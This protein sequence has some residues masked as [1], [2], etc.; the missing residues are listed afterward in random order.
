MR[1]DDV[2][3]L[4]RGPAERHSAADIHARLWTAVGHPELAAA[5]EVVAG[6]AVV[7]D[8]EAADRLRRANRAE[9]VRI[10]ARDLSADDPLGLVDDVAGELS[11]LADGVLACALAIARSQVPGADAIRFAVIG[12]GKCGARELNYLSDV[13]V[14]Y[15]AEPRADDGPTAVE[16]AVAVGNRL[17]AALARLC[18]AHTAA[19]SIWQLDA[20]LRPEGNAGPLARTLDA[21]SAYYHR[22]ASDWEF[23]ALLKARPVAGDRALG[24]AFCEAVAPLVWQVGSHEGFIG[25][26]RAMRQRV[27]DHIPSDQRDREVK[28]G[29]GGLRDIEFS[30][31]ILQLVHG[32]A[33][34]RLRLADTLGG[35]RALT[36]H[37]Y[38]GRPEGELLASAYRFERCLEHRAQ[39]WHLHRTHLLPTEPA[40]QRR[41]ARSLRGGPDDD[42]W[43]R[44]R[45]TS[46]QVRQ[47]QQRVFYS[48]LLEAVSRVPSDALALSSEAAADRLR[49]LG[50]LDQQAAL[51]HIAAL[52]D[53]V[54]R[55]AEIQR[56][57][58]PAMLGW[59]AEGPNPDA[60]LLAFRQISD[61]LGT[62]AWYL[63]AL[64]DEG[65]T[66]ERLAR[67]PA[68]SRYVVDLLRRDPSSIQ[69][70]SEDA[71]LV[72]RSRA[73]LT[74][75]MTQ[76]GARHAN[77]AEAIEAIRALRRRELCRIALGDLV[78]TLDL[79]AV[80]T[81]LSDLTGATVDAALGVVAAGVP[82][83]PPLGVIAMGRWGGG[84]MGYASDAD[85]MIVVPD[86]TTEAGMTAAAAVVTTARSLLG[87]AG[88]EPKLDLDLDLRP[89]GR[90]GALVRS[91]AS[92]AAYYAQWSATWE[93]QALVRAV[94]GAGDRELAARLLDAVAPLRWP[95]EGLGED[96]IRAIR[97]MKLRVER[98]RGGRQAERARNL[99]L[100][101][102]GLSDIEWTVQ[103]LQLRHAG[104]VPALRTANTLAALTA[105]REAGVIEAADAG[106]LAAAWTLVSR[107]RNAVILARGRASDTLPV[108]PREMAAVAWILGYGPRGGSRLTEEWERVTR[109]AVRV[110]DRL[111]WGQGAGVRS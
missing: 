50:F 91:V 107:L 97:H 4:L 43:G 16:Q 100:G 2:L 48:P 65:A 45:S 17:A 12:L 18:S 81:G 5:D 56:Q 69:L 42:L 44:W 63:R 83:A 36:D 80:G 55:T 39:L 61:E 7:T 20:G 68:G 34:E 110:V 38:V 28:L 73:D 30:V 106:T 86:D 51:R 77:P 3:P 6:E 31:Q 95:A 90:D 74:E 1:A 29:T 25:A 94:A 41:I 52:T 76:A 88:A 27:L 92:Y 96:G 75:S 99:K 79:D 57:L 82:G 32:R 59:L 54:T 37:G 103:L 108:D 14:L 70:L 10:A 19:G 26:S 109:R 93:A 62:T 105:A 67:L 89:E 111:F 13:D 23:Q 98:E 35:L 21:L 49:G 72:P 24:R 9:L 40:A 84:E 58:M 47:L 78:G 102:G 85:A 101:P 71:A 66:A 60:G 22:W 104:E 8:P 46:A 11:D 64:R 53:G 87:A 15:V 33:D